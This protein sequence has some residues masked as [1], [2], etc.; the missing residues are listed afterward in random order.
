MK[1]YK[2]VLVSGTIRSGKDTFFTLLSELNPNFIGY[3]FAFELK[4]DLK[5]LVAQMGIDIHNPTDEQKKVIRNLMIVYG[6]TWREIDINHWVKKVDWLIDNLAKQ[7]NLWMPVVR[8]CRFVSEAEYFIEKYGRE[9][10]LIVE[11]R[12]FGAPTP[13]AEELINQPKITEIA[14]VILEWETDPSFESLRPKVK[15]FYDKF[16]LGYDQ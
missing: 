2:V 13:P 15:Y 1:K 5:P 8:D 3:S 10:I 16:F 14:D 12:R 11:I 7:S 6:C 4:E 9:N